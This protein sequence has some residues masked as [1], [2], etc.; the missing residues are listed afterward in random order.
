MNIALPI[1]S[2]PRA[3]PV[4]FQFWYACQIYVLAGLLASQ[5][6]SDVMR[7][8]V[9]ERFAARRSSQCCVGVVFAA[10]RVRAFARLAN[11]IFGYDGTTRTE[12]GA[13]R[14]TRSAMLPTSTCWKPVSPC[15]DVM[16]RSTS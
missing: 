14:T 7:R 3:D 8:R 1:P 13:W 16:I 15:V 4:A 6:D 2:R 10:V 5:H 9:V 12:Q 11:L